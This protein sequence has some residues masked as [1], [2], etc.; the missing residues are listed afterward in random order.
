MDFAKL[1]RAIFSKIEIEMPSIYTYHGLHHT[2]YVLYICEKYSEMLELKERDAI[3][4]KTAAVLHDV[5]LIWNYKDH[6]TTS[7]NYAKVILSDYGYGLDEI[8]Q[9]C[10][11]I[12]ATRIPQ[13]PADELSKIL[14][15]ADLDYLGT[16]EFYKVSQTL[17]HEFL[18]INI[19]N[20]E[21]EYD[22][23]QIKFLTNHHYHTD[24]AKENREPIKQDYLNALLE[25]RMEIT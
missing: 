8:D 9:I 24:F 19:V 6:E 18:S 13:N 10:E 1:K 16:N 4:L 12:E 11:M 20:N 25:K 21:E 5:G 23:I 7:I 15:D 3:I 22:D 2:E 14:C 17:F